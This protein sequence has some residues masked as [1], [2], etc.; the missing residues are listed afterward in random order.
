MKSHLANQEQ[1]HSSSLASSL[2]MIV[3]LEEVVSDPQELAMLK[4]W[5]DNRCFVP[6]KSKELLWLRFR[7]DFARKVCFLPEIVEPNVW[8]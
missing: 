8:Q 2:T 5:I 1:P 7:R 4:E 6:E 3:S